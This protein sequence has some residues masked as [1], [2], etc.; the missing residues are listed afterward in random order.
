MSDVLKTLAEKVKELD[1]ANEV[2]LAAQLALSN[3]QEAVDDLA[4]RE[5]PDLLEEVGVDTITTKDGLKV[6]IKETVHAKIKVDDRAEAYEWLDRNGHSALIRRNVVVPF[7]KEDTE[8]CE[9]LVNALEADYPDLSVDMNVHPSTLRSFVKREI[10]EDE[11]FPRK[12]FGVFIR[13]QATI[14]KNG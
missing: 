12:L 11:D 14:E 2:L 6:S 8:K 9:K 3:A 7:Q 13:K 4:M 10:E 5:I 1:D